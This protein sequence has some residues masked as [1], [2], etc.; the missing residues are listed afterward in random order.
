MVL[1][2]GG[3]YQGKL[4]F[5]TKNLGYSKEIFL[6]GETCSFLEVE[7]ASG[8]YQLH[9]LVYRMLKEGLDPYSLI[10]AWEKKTDIVVLC[11]ELG[12]GVV[13]MDAFDREY[14]ECVGRILCQLAKKSNRVY[15]VYCGIGTVIK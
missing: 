3:A 1:I 8:M 15:R 12:C 7:Q 13:P 4:A 14:R 5:A 11:N 2:I 9:R 6:D 10:T